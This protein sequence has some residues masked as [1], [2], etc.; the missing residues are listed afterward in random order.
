[1]VPLEGGHDNGEPEADVQGEPAR[2]APFDNSTILVNLFRP[3]FPKADS[4]VKNRVLFNREDNISRVGR[5][6]NSEEL[7]WLSVFMKE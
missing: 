5:L 4:V 1:V 7:G 2:G 3:I 6:S